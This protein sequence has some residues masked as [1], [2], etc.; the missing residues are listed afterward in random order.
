[1]S[2]YR[3]LAL[4]GRQQNQHLLICLGVEAAKEIFFKFLKITGFDLGA[5]SFDKPN[6]KSLVMDCRQGR[7]DHL[8]AAEEVV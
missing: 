2:D 7:A 5:H 3:N 4:A 1:M 8:F 6:D